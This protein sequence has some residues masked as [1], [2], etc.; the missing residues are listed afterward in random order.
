MGGIKR[1]PADIAF[2]KCVREAAAWVCQK[3]K[4]PYPPNAKGLE[5]AH[6]QTRGKWSTRFDP[7]NVA[8]LCTG[9]HMYIDSHPHEKIAWFQSHLGEARAEAVRLQSDKPAH[10]LKRR[11]KEIAVH[12]RREHERLLNRRSQGAVGKLPIRGFEDDLQSA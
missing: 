10:G 6:Y 4:T 1:T 2:S 5:C 12:F 7:F 9:C 8:A 3:C 11:V